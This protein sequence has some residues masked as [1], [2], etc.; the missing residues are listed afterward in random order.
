MKRKT[1]ITTN[2]VIYKK[3][4]ML[5]FDNEVVFDNKTSLQINKIVNNINRKEK[6]ITCRK[7]KN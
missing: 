6:I 4:N 3:I 7:I 2:P 1:I 5:Q